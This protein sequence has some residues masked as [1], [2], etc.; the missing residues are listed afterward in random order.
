MDADILFAQL[1]S[2]VEGASGESASAA[3]DKS[4]HMHGNVTNNIY[5]ANAYQEQQYSKDTQA[6][7][8]SGSQNFYG[9]AEYTNFASLHRIGRDLDEPAPTAVAK[10]ADLPI[11]EK[12]GE[13]QSVKKM[14]KAD[15]LLIFK[16]RK[17]R[18]TMVNNDGS[19]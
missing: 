4:Y 7:S 17:Q 9:N 15:D 8:P 14:I 18:S 19:N 12:P 5:V 13:G 1:S 3:N 11:L 2:V 16:V 10:P 6:Y